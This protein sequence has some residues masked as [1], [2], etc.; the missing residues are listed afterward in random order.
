AF[1]VDT[2]HLAGLGVATL[3]GPALFYPEAAEASNLDALS[4]RQHRRHCVKHCVDDGFRLAMRKALLACKKL[5]DY[6]P[7]GHGFR[8]HSRAPI[9]RRRDHATRA[10]PRHRDPGAAP[11]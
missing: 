2:Y 11:R 7:F 5:V 10:V 1:G 4:A 6:T 9:D 8:S 3:A